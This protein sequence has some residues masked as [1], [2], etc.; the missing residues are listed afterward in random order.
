MGG[1]P[2][3][4]KEFAEYMY[5]DLGKPQNSEFDENGGIK[6]ISESAGRYSMFK[7]GPFLSVSHGIGTPSLSVVLHEV[8]SFQ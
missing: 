4:M 2:K 1:K 7:V 6:D 8:G 3:R 5:Q